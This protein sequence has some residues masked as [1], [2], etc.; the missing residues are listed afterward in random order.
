MP[1]LLED[2]AEHALVQHDDGSVELIPWSPLNRLVYRHNLTGLLKD[3]DDVLALTRDEKPNVTVIPNDDA[4]EFDLKVGE[5]TIHLAPHQKSELVDR[6]ADAY[7]GDGRPSVD[8]FVDWAT[9]LLDTR[10]NKSYVNQ[11]AD[12]PV[13]ADSVEVRS[14][15]WFINDHLLLTYDIEFYHPEVASRDAGDAELKQSD[16]EAYKVRLTG[17]TEPGQ[18]A[19]SDFSRIGKAD[20]QQKFIAKALWAV[21]HAPEPNAVL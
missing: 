2:R 17:D 12:L 10:A 13:F 15:G 16:A 11:F 14:D 6:I 1:R 20:D 21:K 3:G 8:P 9:D 5:D 18:S 7:E 4:T 19:L